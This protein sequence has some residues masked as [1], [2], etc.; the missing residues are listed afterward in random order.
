MRDFLE[1]DA[2]CQRFGVF[3]ENII[4]YIFCIYLVWISDY[5]IFYKFKV[6]KNPNFLWLMLP[7]F[8]WAHHTHSIIINSLT[9][10]KINSKQKKKTLH[11]NQ[12]FISISFSIRISMIKRLRW[13]K[14]LYFFMVVVKINKYA[15]FVL[16]KCFLVH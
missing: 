6:N 10:K 1:V 7:Y 8:F 15:V 5:F 12:I 3:M 13:W 4:L 11:R 16:Y 14:S 2:R 9:H